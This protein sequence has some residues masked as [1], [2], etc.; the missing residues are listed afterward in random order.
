MVSKD[1]RK[2]IILDENRLQA[3]RQ[4]CEAY[5]ISLSNHAICSAGQWRSK[6]WLHDF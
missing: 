3:L 1:Y 5:N 4:L 2:K 6:D